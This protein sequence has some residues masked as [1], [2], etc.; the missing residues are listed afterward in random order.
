VVAW[1]LIFMLVILK[2]PL[3]YL[4][5]VVWYAV[6]AEPDVDEPPAEPVGVREP[7]APA[8]RWS[9]R[10]RRRET[11]RR[12]PLRPVRR[13]VSSRPGLARAETAAR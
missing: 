9:P 7:L 2:I 4:C 10:G 12:L 6:R 1:E 13:P 5:G 11:P 3:A 8:P